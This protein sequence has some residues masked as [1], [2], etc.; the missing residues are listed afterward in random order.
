MT[1]GPQTEARPITA[2]KPLLIAFVLAD[3]VLV[4]VAVWYFFLR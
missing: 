2:Y 4:A 1:D 3:L